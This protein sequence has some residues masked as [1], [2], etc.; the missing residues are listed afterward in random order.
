LGNQEIKE[1]QRDIAQL[2][3]PSW[4]SKPPSNFGS[5]SCGNLKADT[6]QSICTICLPIT[7]IRVWGAPQLG[8][9]ENHQQQLLDNFMNLVQVVVLATSHA[10]PGSRQRNASP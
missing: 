10:I 9:L 5:P 7:L 8:A 3:I 6:W 2:I 4:I 1:I